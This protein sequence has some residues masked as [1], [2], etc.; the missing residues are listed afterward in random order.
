MCFLLQPLPLLSPVLRPL[1]TATDS[2]YGNDGDLAPPTCR[3]N[4]F[5]SPGFHLTNVEIEGL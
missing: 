4:A 3:C 5:K 2:A 1:S